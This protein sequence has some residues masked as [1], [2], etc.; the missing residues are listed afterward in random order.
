MKQIKVKNQRLQRL[1][2]SI[3]W[4]H[5]TAAWLLAVA[6]LSIAIKIW[7]MP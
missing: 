3:T 5:V 7:R 6:L 2:D 1:L 4:V